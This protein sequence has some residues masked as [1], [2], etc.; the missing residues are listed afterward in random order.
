MPGAPYK[1]SATPWS[2]PRRAPKLGEHTSEILT[3]VGI[4]EERQTTLRQKGIVR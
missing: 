2:L 4:A 3:A 1:L